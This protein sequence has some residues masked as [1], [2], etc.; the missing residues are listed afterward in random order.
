MII[1]GILSL[2]TDKQKI[3]LQLLYENKQVTFGTILADE[4][5]GIV[6]LKL[7]ERESRTKIKLSDSGKKLISDIL[8]DKLHS[9]KLQGTGGTWH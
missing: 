7:V 3:V 9:R 2:L 1:F 6:N 8:E 5:Q 4:I